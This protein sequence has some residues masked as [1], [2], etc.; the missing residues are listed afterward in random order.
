MSLLTTMTLAL[1]AAAMSIWFS[2]WT[3]TAMSVPSPQAT[4]RIARTW[5]AATRSR[6]TRVELRASLRVSWASPM[7]S[8]L[9]VR[10]IGSPHR[11]ASWTPSRLSSASGLRPAGW[12]YEIGLIARATAPPARQRSAGGGATGPGASSAMTYSVS[13]LSASVKRRLFS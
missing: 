10:R 5:V 4:S 13:S 8:M 11:M 7:L 12:R 1:M 3:S 6:L 9:P 2:C